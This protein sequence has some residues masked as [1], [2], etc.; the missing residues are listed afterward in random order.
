EFG[1][2]VFGQ[3]GFIDY[4]KMGQKVFYNNALLDK[5]NSIIH[6]AVRNHFKQWLHNQIDVPYILNESAIIFEHNLYKELDAVIVVLASED[7]RV[8][9]VIKRDGLKENEVFQRIKNQITDKE[10]RLKGNYFI[11]NDEKLPIIPQVL[12]IHRI[13]LQ[14][15]N[16]TV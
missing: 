2:E 4:K 15:A 11:L 5:L 12:N 13:L 7:T 3:N 10:R 1:E 8:K 16:K 9:R 6:P 14:K